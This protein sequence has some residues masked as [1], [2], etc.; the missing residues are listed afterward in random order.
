MNQALQRVEAA[1]QFGIQHPSVPFPELQ[2]EFKVELS[3]C[4][5]I[6][7]GQPEK[8][9]GIASF[10]WGGCYGIAGLAIVYFVTDNKYG[11]VKALW[12]CIASTVLYVAVYFIAG[13]GTLAA[14]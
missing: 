5:V 10:C 8:K 13:I 1:E 6:N 11:A 9:L 14:Y 3:P 7:S 12:G 2:E 4:A